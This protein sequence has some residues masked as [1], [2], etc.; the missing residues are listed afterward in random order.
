VNAL[1]DLSML[2]DR[3]TTFALISRAPLASLEAIRRKRGGAFRGFL[4]LA[5][6]SITTFM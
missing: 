5:T 2:K 3:D 1:G 4:R 6:I